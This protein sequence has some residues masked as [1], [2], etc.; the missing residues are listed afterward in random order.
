MSSSNNQIENGAPEVRGRSSVVG[1]TKTSQRIVIIGIIILTIVALIYIYNTGRSDS[2]KG[3]NNIQ[4]N[5][6]KTQEKATPV[7]Q[8]D[9]EVI[10]L[11]TKIPELPSL[12][13]PLEVPPTPPPVSKVKEELAQTLPQLPVLSGQS[14]IEVAP[15]G[16]FKYPPRQSD[17]KKG[18][19]KLSKNKD[20]PMLVIS[21]KGNTSSSS[22]SDNV[23][24]DFKPINEINEST[25]LERTSSARV[26]ATYVGDLSSLIL[27]GKVI[28][29]VLETAINT[30]LNGI[31][32]AIISRDVYSESGRNIL[33]Q[34]GCKLIGKYDTSIS[35]AQ[36]RVDIVWNRVICPN[37]LDVQLGS[38][39]TDQ[40][41]RAGISGD[42]DTK[43][44]HL[45][46]NSLLISSV[47]LVGAATINKIFPNST[48]IE[49]VNPNGSI[50][51]TTSIASEAA[52]EAVEKV[53]KVFETIVKQYESAQPTIRVNQGTRIKVFV[54]KD[55]VFPSNMGNKTSVVG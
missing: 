44:G 43:F 32:R 36:S 49:T 5:I 41:G 45:F 16:N 6:Q 4:E 25:P 9:K 12:I 11:P 55:L 20:T 47:N 15:Q 22:G 38:P 13:E 19:V 54:N 34:K 52:V 7:S 30:D 29:A 51:S 21:G 26:R 1:M 28:D 31:L 8:E 42:V 50:T 27:Q 10:S 23:E 35:P 40:L 53:S 24:G 18:K 46:M 14:E 48:S 2:E 17:A 39:G 37:G 3:E 33:L